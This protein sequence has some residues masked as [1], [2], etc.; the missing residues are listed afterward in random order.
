[1]SSSFIWARLL[2]SLPFANANRLS[3]EYITPPRPAVSVSM[4]SLPGNFPASSHC[5][6]S[7]PPFCV[8]IVVVCE[9]VS[10]LYQTAAYLSCIARTTSVPVVGSV[11]R[12]CDTVEGA[13]PV[14]GGVCLQPTAAAHRTTPTATSRGD[15]K[16]T[17]L[18]SSHLVISY[19]V[20]CLKKKTT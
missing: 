8:V 5:C 2:A 13:V 10:V 6:W 16:S 9:N 15:R 18:N 19:A 14:V 4:R 7:V 12:P 11:R 20:F 17:R 1:M 3:P